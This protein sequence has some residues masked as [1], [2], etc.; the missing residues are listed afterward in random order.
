MSPVPT[1]NTKFVVL[2]KQMAATCKNVLCFNSV[3]IGSNGFCSNECEDGA[4]K[5]TFQ[6]PLT[7]DDVCISDDPY[8]VGDKVYCR[9]CG[10]RLA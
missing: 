2:R 7:H 10:E 8:L 9:N 3:E 6:K 5:N 4:Y 1:F